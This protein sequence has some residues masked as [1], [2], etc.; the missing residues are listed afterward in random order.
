MIDLLAVAEQAQ[1]GDLCC[2]E[3]GVNLVIEDPFENRPRLMD[4]S[5]HQRPTGEVYARCANHDG[6]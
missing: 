3:C 5:L 2:I 6:R 1:R 4:C